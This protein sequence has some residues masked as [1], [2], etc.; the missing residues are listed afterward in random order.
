MPEEMKP[1]ELPTQEIDVRTREF[2]MMLVA[3]DTLRLFAEE[4]SR[5]DLR[6]THEERWSVGR[7]G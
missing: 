2:F 3:Q 7:S 5:Q 1:K 4:Q 6:P